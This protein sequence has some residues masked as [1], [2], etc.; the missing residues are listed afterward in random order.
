MS[1]FH[2]N[3]HACPHCGLLYKRFTTGFSY[4]DVY[5]ML[6]DYS[7]DPK[8]W[9]YKRR[10]TVLGAMFQLKQDLWKK[11]VGEECPRH[12]RNLEAMQHVQLA[13]ADLVPF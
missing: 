12:P 7:T 3:D 11:H 2:G 6:M 1:R 8:E 9:K 5:V 13:T 10:N 4:R